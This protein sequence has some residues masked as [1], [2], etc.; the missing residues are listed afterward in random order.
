MLEGR[1]AYIQ[2]RKMKINEALKLIEKYDD[3]I[4]DAIDL[5]E[6]LNF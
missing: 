2:L 6:T 1:L 4:N 3:E 5:S